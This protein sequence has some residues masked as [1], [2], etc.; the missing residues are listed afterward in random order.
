MTAAPSLA[1][2]HGHVRT[3]VIVVLFDEGEQPICSYSP[4]I[5]LKVGVALTAEIDQSGSILTPLSPVI[6]W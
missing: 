6:E 5:T 4:V 1:K 2:S 3:Q